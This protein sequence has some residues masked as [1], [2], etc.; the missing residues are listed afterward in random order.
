MKEKILI[1]KKARRDLKT[2]VDQN[3]LSSISIKEVVTY[4][5]F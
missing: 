2:E 5:F 1:L 3:L 4:F